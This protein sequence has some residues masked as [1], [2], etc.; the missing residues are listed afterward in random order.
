M[1]V[2]QRAA[3]DDAF[4]IGRR[5]LAALEQ[6]AQPFDDLGR[7]ILDRWLTADLDPI[8]FPEI[9]ATALVEHQPR[10]PAIDVVRWVHE[11]PSLVPQADIASEFGQPPITV[12][13]CEHFYIEVLFWLDGTTA[14]HQHSFSGAFSVMEG[15][16]IH[17]TYRFHPER[18]FNDRLILG[19]LEW[20]DTELL[21]QAIPLILLE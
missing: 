3:H 9:A 15:S 7:L 14:I 5:H 11:T 2:R 21:A 6:G 1:A 18:R 10:L 17:S 20:L 8:A 13:R 12:F 4:L 16:S 19:R